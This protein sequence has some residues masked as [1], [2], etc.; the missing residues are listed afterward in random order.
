MC[1]ILNLKM[2]IKDTLGPKEI[3][4]PIGISL[5]SFWARDPLDRSSR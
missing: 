1:I 4:L 2:E 5:L 3:T